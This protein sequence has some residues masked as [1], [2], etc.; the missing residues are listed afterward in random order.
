MNNI[1]SYIQELIKIGNIEVQYFTKKNEFLYISS[2]NEDILLDL[3]QKIISEKDIEINTFMFSFIDEK[4]TKH[5]VYKNNENIYILEFINIVQEE[6]EEMRLKIFLEAENG[7]IVWSSEDYQECKVLSSYKVTLDEHQITLFKYVAN[8]DAFVLDTIPI[9]F[10]KY[11]NENST[12]KIYNNER[13]LF[14]CLTKELY[15]IKFD[16]SDIQQREILTFIFLNKDIIVNDN[17]DI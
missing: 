8:D 5:K 3:E 12:I 2:S 6:E 11:L 7:E 4:T 13:F 9:T 15:E 17:V 16:Y 1:S 14:S 10:K